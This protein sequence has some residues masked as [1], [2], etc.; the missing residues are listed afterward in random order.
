VATPRP[1][2]N[3]PT[4]DIVQLLNTSGVETGL[5]TTAVV[6]AARD[7]ADMLDLPHQSHALLYGTRED[8][9]NA[10]PCLTR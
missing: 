2:G 6:E 7:I 4:E 10:K 9:L 3:L 8:L 5:S 1:I